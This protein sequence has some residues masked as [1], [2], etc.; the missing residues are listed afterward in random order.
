MWFKNLIIY[1]W[2]QPFTLSQQKLEEQLKK[3]RFRSCGS[4]DLSTYG[5]VPPSWASR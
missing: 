1:R 3:K 2:T 4:Q 5:W